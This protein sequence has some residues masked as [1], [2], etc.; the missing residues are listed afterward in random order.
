MSAETYLISMYPPFEI[1]NE[2]AL[3]EVEGVG[4]PRLSGKNIED[5]GTRQKSS[6]TSRAHPVI[7]HAFLLR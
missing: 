7:R 4:Q 6:P 3:S 2:P 5:W 1:R